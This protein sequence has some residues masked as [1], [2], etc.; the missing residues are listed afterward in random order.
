MA[1][2]RSFLAR[3][4]AAPRPANG[5][6][7]NR[8]GRRTSITA[9]DLESGWLHVAH[10]ALR[11]STP[12]ITRHAARPLPLPAPADNRPEDPAAL[13]ETIA[14][15]LAQARLD[16]GP[17]VLGIPR[18]QAILRVLSLPPAHRASEIAAMVH[19]Q[20]RRDLPFPIED[21]VLDFLVLPPAPETAASDPAPAPAP[22]PGGEGSPASPTSAATHPTRVLVAVVRRETVAFHTDLARAAGFKLQAL[23]LRPLAAGR[24]AVLCSP[25]AARGCTAIISSRGTE[26]AFD[27]LLDGT[28]AFS[29]VGSLPA[30]PRPESALPPSADAPPAAAAPGP[31][32][33]DTAVLETS[34]SLHSYEGTPGHHRIDTFLVTGT[35]GAEHDLGEALAR[36]FGIPVHRLDPARALAGTPLDDAHPNGA[37]TAIGLA[38]SA[39]DPDGLPIDFLAPKRPPAPRDH[40]RVRRLAFAAAGLALLLSV[41]G[42]RA[43]WIRQ[44]ER[45]R[46]DL[47]A[48]V[49][50]ATKNLAGFRAVRTQARSVGD[51]IAGSRNW[52]DHLALLGALL[53]PSRDLYLTAFSTSARNNLSLSV[54]VRG[55]EILDRL[56]ADLRAAGYSVKPAGIT[57]V[58]DRFGYRFQATLEI[59]VPPKLTNDLDHLVVEPRPDRGASEIPPPTTDSPTPAATAAP[60]APTVPPASPAVAATVTAVTAGTEPPTE[61][62]AVGNPATRGGPGNPEER[63]NRRFRR[64]PEGAPPP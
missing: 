32:L 34:R 21:A 48:Q 33:V 4:A 52:L 17:V 64:R 1:F 61:A 57:P 22:P 39:L 14:R 43:H 20:V 49:T 46:T 59:E 56:G 18:S 10:A 2:L 63:P 47:Q 60:P 8:R 38:V 16:V 6:E 54:R 12:R 40:R 62:P 11:G 5:E 13:G 24:A 58:N 36:S 31:S 27:V 55:G 53:P 37:L 51:W 42:L 41:L 26:I 50:L 28:L 44:R 23:A 7:R 3:R 15:T 35:T 9:V 29:R 25:E 19:L 45:V 30:P